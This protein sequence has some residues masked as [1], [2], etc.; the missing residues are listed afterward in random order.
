MCLPKN[1]ADVLTAPILQNAD[2]LFFLKYLLK[3]K[4]AAPDK[5]SEAA[6]LRYFPK[7]VF[8]KI[9]FFPS[10]NRKTSQIQ[11]TKSIGLHALSAPAFLSQSSSFRRALHGLCNKTILNQGVMCLKVRAILDIKQCYSNINYVTV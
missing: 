10:T 3:V 8:L 11:R 7:Q 6:V 5:F 2:R 1:F 9:S 4:I